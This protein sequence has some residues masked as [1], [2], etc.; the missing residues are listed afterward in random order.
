[1]A[2]N[3]QQA[4]E[5]L[6]SAGLKYTADQVANLAKLR[7]F[8]NATK[9]NNGVWQIP[10]ESVDAF[11]KQRRQGQ[12]IRLITGI[13]VGS[14]VAICGCIFAAISGMKDG[15]DLLVS[16]LPSQNTKH[17]YTPTV[18]A[19]PQVADA[20][21][22]SSTRT[23]AP[24]APTVAPTYTSLAPT[25]TVIPPLAYPTIQIPMV[26]EYGVLLYTDI[27][28]V[29]YGV[30]PV[31]C[32]NYKVEMS[33][34]LGQSV[35][36]GKYDPDEQRK[37]ASLMQ[38]SVDIVTENTL[39][40]SE[41]VLNAAHSFPP[42][43]EDVTVLH[44]FFIPGMGDVPVVRYPQTSIGK[45]QLSAHISRQ[46]GALRLDPGDTVRLSFPI[47]FS[48]PGTYELHFSIVGQQATGQRVDFTSAIRYGWFELR[49][50]S[51]TQLVSDVFPNWTKYEWVPCP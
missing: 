20:P 23:P 19:T 17:L 50:V 9:D 11:I 36:Y 48:D 32:S 6:A 24:S 25:A 30:V 37:Y 35:E 27:S 7:V 15:L 49:D 46:E 8:A 40:V 18:L 14:I 45:S 42:S 3:T 47:L 44:D 5:K 33:G 12:R 43:D 2:L 29:R 31:G 26:M 39:V 13:T 4:A 38:F 1:M 41:V 51:H 28:G 21:S 22:N 16:V 34:G 10:E